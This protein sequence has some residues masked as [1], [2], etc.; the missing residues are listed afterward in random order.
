MTGHAYDRLDEVR[1]YPPSA[2]FGVV[3]PVGIFGCG[4]CEKRLT[5]PVVVCEDCE[6]PL[7]VQGP[8]EH[9]ARKRASGAW[10]CDD[11]D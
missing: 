7:D 9:V 1:E 5:R 4:H 11:C 10:V 3:P 8:P 2:V 6:R